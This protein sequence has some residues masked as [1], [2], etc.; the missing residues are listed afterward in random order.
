MILTGMRSKAEGD[1]QTH[2]ILP[3]SMLKSH[4]GFL[5]IVTRTACTEEDSRQG[6]TYMVSRL[7]LHPIINTSMNKENIQ[8]YLSM[9]TPLLSSHLFLVLS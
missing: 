8:S 1:I 4:D 9:W 7:L 2:T 5:Y 3:A 6:F